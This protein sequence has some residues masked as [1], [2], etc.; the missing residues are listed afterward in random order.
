MFPDFK[1]PWCSGSV[2]FKEDFDKI[3]R[4]NQT[5]DNFL[6]NA[7]KYIIDI[8]IKLDRSITRNKLESQYASLIDKIDDMHFYKLYYHYSKKIIKK[9]IKV[10]KKILEIN[11]EDSEVEKSLELLISINEESG[12][13]LK[14][15][16]EDESDRLKELKISHLLM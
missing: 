2:K 1:I 16:T 3:T 15:L 13:K 11:K 4:I 6:K 10:L 14:E 8:I 9:R 7:K 5:K 12:A